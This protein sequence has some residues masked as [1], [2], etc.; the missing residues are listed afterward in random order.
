[1]RLAIARL[2]RA[3]GPPAADRAGHRRRRAGRGRGGRH[4]RHRLRRR[5]Q[6]LESATADL[7]GAA[8]V[9][10]RAFAD[11]GF[12]PRTLQALRAMPEV[13]VAAP[14]SERRLLVSTA[15]GENEQVFTLLVL[16]RRPGHRRRGARPAPDRRA[17]RRR[18]TAR[19]MRWC[20]LRG[21]RATGSGSGT[22]SLLGGRR[23]GMPPL[24]IIGLLRGH[25]PGRARARRR[26]RHCR[27]PRSTTRSR[28][29]RRSARSTSCWP[30]TTGD[31]G[32]VAAV[33]DSLDEPFVV[34][35]AEDAA[36]RLAS[37]QAGF[38]GVA[39]LFGLVALMVGAFL[40]GNTLAMTVG[41]RTRE[42]GLLRAAGTTSRQVLGI[43]LRQAL[44]IG[45]VGSLLGVVLG[46]V[47]AARHHRLPR[48]RR[49]R[50][51]WPACRCR[52]SA[53]SWRSRSG[54]R[55]TLAGA[56]R[57]RASAPR[58]CRR[59]TPCGPRA[60]PG[61]GL[62][63]RLRPVIIGE[64]VRRGARHPGGPGG[65]R[66]HAGP[67][68]AAGP[69][70]PGR[71]GGR[72]RLRPRAAGHA[73]VGRPFEWFFGAQG[74]LGRANLARDRVR[75]GLT[76]GR[77]DDR[78]RCRR[79][80]RHGRRV[81]ARAAPS[82]GSHRSCPAAT[83]SASACR[84]TSRRSAHAGGDDRAPGRQPR[85]RARRP[86]ASRTTAGARRR[87]RHRPQRVPG[88]GRADR[89]AALPAPTPSPPCA[90]AGPCWCPRSLAGRE[91]IGVGDTRR[92]R[93]CRAAE[94]TD[95]CVAGIVDYTLAGAHGGRG[96]ADQ[97]R[98]R[99]RSVRRDD[100]RRCGSWSRSRTSP[101]SV[102]R[103]G[104]PRDSRPACAA[105]PLT[106]R[107]LA[108]ELARSLDPLIGLF[109]VLALIAVV[110]G[111][112]GIVNTLGHRHQ[113]ARARDRDPSLA[114]H[115]GGPG[116]GHG[117]RRGRDHGRDRRACSPSSTGLVVAFALVGS[118]AAA[119]LGRRACGCPGRCWSRWC[120]WAPALRRWRAS[121]RR[122]WRP[123][124]RS[125]ASLKQ[126][127]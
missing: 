68:A 64:L 82:A 109:D 74:L 114:R 56:L 113:R 79:R 90:T 60:S 99:A 41:E 85:P 15:P 124:C 1:M 50:S 111:A 47:L 121:T 7:L 120:W 125:C 16:G 84:S 36:A 23:E 118:G 80:A 66:R 40:V 46:I 4:D 95:F 45:V 122:G 22:S 53:C 104:G 30:A 115:D 101:A 24:R 3:A 28:S 13:A 103:R 38:V 49:A 33:T 100:G 107:D 19:P 126:F 70:A 91:G 39:F 11:A 86:C 63:D 5:E 119:E 14:V 89:L 18:A 59:S 17:S 6:A 73:I 94:A 26:A 52:R 2:A 123:R 34:E 35:T 10:L 117:R 29:R 32:A 93:R 27:A 97:L 61:R 127:E 69:R 83:P 92:A 81:G 8:D 112:L 96:A 102:V 88:R 62:A 51:W 105:E 77:D 25:R 98:R 75:T 116:P 106:A 12:Q 54:L 78:P 87:G 72:D 67:A 31:A 44:A 21:R 71:R 43:V 9:R 55:V 42:L 57:S 65:R 110:I 108:G 20:P 37:A 48:R 76:V 58:G